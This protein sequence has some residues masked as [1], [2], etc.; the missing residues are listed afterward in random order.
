[1]L[2]ISSIPFCFVIFIVGSF[3]FHKIKIQKNKEKRPIIYAIIRR[4]LVFNHL[5]KK[6]YV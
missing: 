3:V 1:M 5:I 4:F 2:K 6:Y